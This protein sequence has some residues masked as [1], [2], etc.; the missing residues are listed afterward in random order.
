[1]ESIKKG[2]RL[3]MLI[4]MGQYLYYQKGA[5][6]ISSAL[7]T[8]MVERCGCIL[9][10]KRQILSYLLSYLKFL[11]KNKLVCPLN[12][13]EHVVE[14]NLHQKSSKSIA[15]QMG[16]KCNYLLHICRNKIE[17]LSGRIER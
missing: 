17:S 7:L 16:S 10:P 8:T 14:V 1:M 5:K 13:K 6:G 4:F 11:W 12:V 9:L 3:F 15:E 2:C